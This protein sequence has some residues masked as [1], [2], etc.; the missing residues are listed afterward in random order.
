MKQLNIVIA[1]LALS[2]LI[3]NVYQAVRYSTLQSAIERIQS[4]QQ[5]IISENKRVLAAIALLRAPDV[6]QQRSRAE[7][8]LDLLQ[9]ERNIYVEIDE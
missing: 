6:I 8:G 7:L 2:L 3:T 9:Q 5:V 1:F 4:E